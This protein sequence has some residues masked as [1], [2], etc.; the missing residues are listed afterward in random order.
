MPKID[1][2]V[3]GRRRL[4]MP[5]ANDVLEILLQTSNNTV[6]ELVRTLWDQSVD[7]ASQ[8]EAQKEILRLTIDA[9]ESKEAVQ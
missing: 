6:R 1:Y 7:L 4:A 2:H 8:L 3:P 5:L 9:Y